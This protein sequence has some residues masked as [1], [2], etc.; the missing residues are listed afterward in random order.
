MCVQYKY[1][2]EVFA[3]PQCCG[4]HRR[5]HL[6]TQQRLASLYALGGKAGQALFHDCSVVGRLT[7]LALFNLF[8]RP[9][10]RNDDFLLI[11]R[12]LPFLSSLS[13]A[14][15]IME[16]VLG[17]LPQ[18][19]ALF[20]GWTDTHTDT[21]TRQLFT[22]VFFFLSLHLTQCDFNLKKSYFHKLSNSLYFHKM[23]FWKQCIFFRL[24]RL[25]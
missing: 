5:W 11:L 21:H 9:Q 4:V 2:S 7:V 8:F 25:Q 3:S 22:C 14:R 17:R 15:Q 18:K 12:V 16:Y 13:Q 19:V 20:V 23:T 10:L 6:G 24:M 1:Q